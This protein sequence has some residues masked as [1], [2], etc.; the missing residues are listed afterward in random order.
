M[1]LLAAFLSIAAAAGFSL[2]C[3]S[4]MIMP[5]IV[6]NFF[7]AHRKFFRSSLTIFLVPRKTFEHNKSYSR[8]VVKAFKNGLRVVLTAE[9][10][11]NTAPDKVVRLE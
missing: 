8:K 5:F 4:T 3:S 9:G 7:P 2:F 10:I 6:F 11:E 1:I